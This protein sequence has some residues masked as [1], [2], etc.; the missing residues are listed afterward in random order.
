M[1]K[2]DLINQTM[3]CYQRD[4]P[5]WKKIDE[6]LVGVKNIK[7]IEAGGFEMIKNMVK[8]NWG[9]SIV[10]ELAQSRNSV[11]LKDYF[12]IIPF[13]EYQDLTYNVTGIYKKE[14]PNLEKLLLFLNTFETALKV[15]IPHPV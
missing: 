10:P 3:I 9:F 2:E 5:I 14:S 4:T 8:N 15:M 13:P 1:N 6:K 12:C 11:E 7:R